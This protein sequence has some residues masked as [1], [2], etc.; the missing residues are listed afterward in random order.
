VLL[1]KIKNADL[2]PHFFLPLLRKERTTT[3]AILC[4]P[5]NAGSLATS[6]PVA[7]TKNLKP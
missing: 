7:G 1:R 5:F 4:P 3:I 6:L 2:D